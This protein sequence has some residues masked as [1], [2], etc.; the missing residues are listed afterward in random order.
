[1]TK[2]LPKIDYKLYFALFIMGFIPTIYLSTRIFLIG[3][4]PTDYGFNI[5]RQ[6][7]YVN[8][9][10]E[11]TTEAIILPLFFFVGSVKDDLKELQNRVRTILLFCFVITVVL[12]VFLFI[13]AKPLITF[14]AQDTELIDLTA[15]YIRL[16]A[17]AYIFAILVK[18]I[19]ALLISFEKSYTIYILLV[20]Q[21]FFTIFFDVVFL[22]ELQFSLNIGVLGIA[23]SNIITNLI[24]F[25]T[26]VLL[27]KRSKFH[28][29]SREK[30]D[31]YWFKNMKNIS[32]ISGIETL[33]RN[34]AF[35]FMIFRMINIADGQGDFW[36]ANNF[37]WKFVL[38]PILALGEL[39][40]RDVSQNNHLKTK[41]YFK[42]TTIILVLLVCSIPLW[43]PFLKNVLLLETHD[44]VYFLIMVS[45]GFYVLFAY[46]NVIDSIFYG[47]GRTDLMLL[48]SIII[49]VL[50][51][52]SMY[53]LYVLGIYVPT[54]ASVAIMF[55][56][57]IALDSIVTFI[58]FYKTKNSLVIENNQV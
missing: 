1:M 15:D 28:I 9:I 51:Y 10:Y 52:G 58:I 56:T 3:N 46:N 26:G 24:L 35:M 12:A 54:L 34:L 6:L 43:Q 11:I 50:F 53:I 17:V 29:F 18:I 44:K 32:I 49:N 36:V 47:L 2:F 39:V 33:I 14:M 8:L 45:I 57:G 41:D 25:I 31:F 55:G 22:S 21:M 23:Y 7:T 13:F 27:L 20:I 5:A 38:L 16:E 30:L 40:K 4:L 19:L 37:I 48:Q 42:F